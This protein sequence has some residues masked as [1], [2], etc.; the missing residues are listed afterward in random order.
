MRKVL[1]LFTKEKTKAQNSCNTLTVRQFV[2]RGP[3]EER[4]ILNLLVILGL[5]SP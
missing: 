1:D 2:K 5:L 3:M 4:T